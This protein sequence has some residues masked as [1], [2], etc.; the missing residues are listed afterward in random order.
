M[1]QAG[2]CVGKRGGDEREAARHASAIETLGSAPRPRE[3]DGGGDRA[4]TSG[5]PRRK[6]PRRP[7]PPLA[8]PPRAYGRL[9][10]HPR[11][12]RPRS[13]SPRRHPLHPSRSLRG[14]RVR[15]RPDRGLLSSGAGRRARGGAAVVASSSASRAGRWPGF[16]DLNTPHYVVYPHYCST[17]AVAVPRCAMPTLAAAVHCLTCPA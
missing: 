13:P 8:H 16:N 10:V 2:V 9:W 3:T 17:A 4:V 7:A 15:Q 5:R 14:A 1:R 6:P 11:R 12:S